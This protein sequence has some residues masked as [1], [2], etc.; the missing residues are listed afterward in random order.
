[1]QCLL[2]G[3]AIGQPLLPCPVSGQPKILV[4]GIRQVFIGNFAY[5]EQ[6]RIEACGCRLPLQQKNQL[7]LQIIQTGT[8]FRPDT[9]LQPVSERRQGGSPAGLPDPDR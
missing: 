7:G 6:I 3:T 9:A 5:F 1:M 4:K 2:G 8:G